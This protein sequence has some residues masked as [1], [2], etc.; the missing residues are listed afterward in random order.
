MMLLIYVAEDGLVDISGEE[1]LGPE[2]VQ[3]PIVGNASVGG[4]E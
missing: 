3:H 2:D 1:A 4:W